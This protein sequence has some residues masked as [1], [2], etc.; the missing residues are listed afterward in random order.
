MASGRIFRLKG[1]ATRGAT[2][3]NASVG[4]E[5]VAIPS[6]IAI[7]TSLRGVNSQAVPRGERSGVATSLK[8]QQKNARK[9]R[10][11]LNSSG[12]IHTKYT[13]TT[14]AMTK[15]AARIADGHGP[16]RACR[17]K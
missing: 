13:G 10:L 2:N 7:A 16:E 9:A 6:R 11:K 14:D 1:E 4:F 15:P 3:S 8:S 17:N 12:M 5:N